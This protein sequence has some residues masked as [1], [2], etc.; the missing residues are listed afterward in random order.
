MVGALL[1]DTKGGQATAPSN[2]PFLAIA[3]RA[4]SSTFRGVV[5]FHFEPSMPVKRDLL[6]LDDLRRRI[7]PDLFGHAHPVAAPDLGQVLLGV[8]TSQ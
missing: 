8:A 7:A 5:D 6:I 2:P 1:F 3:F 4:S